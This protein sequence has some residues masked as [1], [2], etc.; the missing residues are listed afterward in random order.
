[1][2]H[3]GGNTSVKLRE[4]DVFGEEIEVRI[5][6]FDRERSRVSLGL[7]QLGA[8]PWANIARRYPPNTRLFGKVTNIADYGCFV[9]IEEGVEGLVHV[10]QLSTERVDR[11]AALYK[12]GDEIEAEVTQVDAR[13]KRIALSI[14][15]L[16]RSEERDEV[17]AYMRRESEGGKFSFAD[18]M[19]EDLENR[20][21]TKA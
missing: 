4:R 3:G 13:E 17:D 8:D 5:L 20:D 7:K 9:E 19:S 12:V 6:K 16:R 1:M 18:I 11:P 14:K 15:A 21:K 2:L 10:S